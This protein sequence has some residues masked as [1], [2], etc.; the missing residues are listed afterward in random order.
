[1]KWVDLLRKTVQQSVFTTGFVAAG[2]NLTQVRLQLS[3]WVKDGRLIRVR[4]GLYILSEPYR[5]INPEPFYL[6]NALKSASYVSLQSVLAYRCTGAH[7]QIL[8]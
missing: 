1:M 5:K 8:S 7:N 2:E 6:A 4:R 3:R